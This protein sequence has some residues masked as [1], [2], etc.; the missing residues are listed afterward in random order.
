MKSERWRSRRLKIVGMVLWK[1]VKG[2][3]DR[4]SVCTMGQYP[5]QLKK[6]WQRE[7]E[8]EMGTGLSKGDLDHEWKSL[9][10]HELIGWIHVWFRNMVYACIQCLSGWQ[11]VMATLVSVGVWS[12][13][14]LQ[15]P[16]VLLTWGG[17]PIAQLGF[18]RLGNNFGEMSRF[19][20]K[21]SLVLSWP[22]QN[23]FK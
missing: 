23:H 4:T 17:L 15:W 8:T 3:T 11:V 13:V 10:H 7:G 20:L 6:E 19:H 18:G 21:K 12:W 1:N 9:L 5:C 22:L 16:Y 14:L 2:N